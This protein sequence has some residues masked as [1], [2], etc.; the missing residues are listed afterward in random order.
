MIRRFVADDLKSFV[1]NEYS[2]HKG[3]DNVFED[4][5]WHKF[6][7]ILYGKTMAI[8]LAREAEKDC[9]NAFFL[10][11]RDFRAR[12]AFH[13][14]DFLAGLGAEYGV[15]L[16]ESDGL[17]CPTINQWH[18]YL[19]FTLAPARNKVINGREFQC[20]EMTFGGEK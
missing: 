12:D 1:P 17:D 9:Y 6:S 19:G 8:V 16:I 10:I 2:E 20:W 4:D 5:A 18:E 7:L 14:K 3:I 11:D 13:L 15:K